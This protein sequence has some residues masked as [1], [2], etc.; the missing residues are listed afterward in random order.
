MIVKRESV[1]VRRRRVALGGL[2]V[3][4]AVTGF[5]VTH[6]F[7][8]DPAQA[9]AAPRPSATADITATAQPVKA[10]PAPSPQRSSG[11]LAPSAQTSLVQIQRLTGGLT[12]K[13]V[14]ASA[15]GQVFAQNMMYSHTISAFRADGALMATIKDGVDLA[16]FGVKGHPGISKGAP[17]EM[18]FSPNGKTAWVS[19]YAM[20][21]SRFSP[22][23]KDACTSG[24]GISPS[25]VYKI[26]TAT[27][28]V[29][30]VVEAG[31]VPK[32]VAVTPDGKNWCSRDLTVLD[33]AKAKVV[34]TVK[35]PGAHPRG[36]AVSKDSKT[37]YVAVM[38]SDRVVAVD[39]LKGKVR[40]F[41][42]TGA[43]PR[44]LVLSKD[45]KTLYVTNNRAGTVSA[46]DATTGTV[47]HT[48]KV[49]KE[50]RSMAISSD[51]GALYVVNYDDSTMTKIRTSDLTAVQ[52]VKTDGYPV[53]VT[54]EPTNKRVWV[55]CYGGSILVFDDSR[56][57]A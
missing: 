52:T 29:T 35:I 44:H 24:K 9:S 1:Y 8:G 22:E 18:A 26:N 51:G 15:H 45:G 38:G 11:R 30:K 56:T 47:L 46:V 10:A 3:F 19:N 43:G 12:P 41:A 54:Y 17:V 42:T 5:G 48:L 13:S 39:L 40:A 23:G 14:V 36:I 21:G 20:Y 2:A 31:A 49:G 53:G 28:A 7:G 6:V 25:Y 4:V 55:A 57:A 27:Y 34:A 50:P 16:A 37:A 32:Y 33:A